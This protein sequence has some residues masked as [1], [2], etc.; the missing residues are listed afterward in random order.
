MTTYPGTPCSFRAPF[1]FCNCLVRR[2]RTGGRPGALPSSTSQADTVCTAT[3]PARNSPCCTRTAR[4]RA[5][6]SRSYRRTRR[7]SRAWH[8]V[9]RRRGRRSSCRSWRGRGGSQR[10]CR[11]TRSRTCSWRA[12]SSPAARR[13]SRQ[14]TQR[15]CRSRTR[16]Y[17]SRS[18]TVHTPRGRCAAC[19]S[20]VC[21]VCTRRSLQRFSRS[22][23][24]TVCRALRHC[25]RTPVHTCSWPLLCCAAA[26]TQRQVDT[27]CTRAAL[28]C[29]CTSPP[30]TPRTPG[31]CVRRR[32]CSSGGW[33]S[34]PAR[35][36]CSDTVCTALGRAPV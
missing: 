26:S 31:L 33:C 25:P 14:D 11:S 20:L 15:S 36:S 23:A 12:Q 28:A 32:T 35:T 24:H 7:G 22:Q 2:G 5:P 9:C 18:R 4:W 34:P 13:W 29:P 3:R 30:R 16:A 1:R 21:T 17:T 10:R 27:P 19:T 8:T 6:N